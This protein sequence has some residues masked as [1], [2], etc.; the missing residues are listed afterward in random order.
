M[1]QADWL[2]NSGW[3]KEK[4]NIILIHG[5]AGGDDSLPIAVIKDGV[6]FEINFEN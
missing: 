2:R 6:Y 3:N 4:Q 5:Y 1:S